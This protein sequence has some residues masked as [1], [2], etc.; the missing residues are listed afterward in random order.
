MKAMTVVFVAIE[1]SSIWLS[2]SEA[3]VKQNEKDSI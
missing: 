2:T 1:N 3:A